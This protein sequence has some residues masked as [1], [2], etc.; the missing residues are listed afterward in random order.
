MKNAILTETGFVAWPARPWCQAP[1]SHREPG[2]LGL[3][4]CLVAGHTW[5]G[6]TCRSCGGVRDAHHESVLSGCYAK[7]RRCG[8]PLAARHE[9]AQVGC[10][11]QCRRCDHPGEE[12]HQMAG[13]V[14]TVCGV[15]IS[16]LP[17]R[18][19]ST[20]WTAH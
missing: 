6:C 1:A 5:K 16:R 17:T 7:C 9:W 20:S 2:W 19:L 11:L 18:D 14:C 10:Q 8:L 3:L 12:V 15:D 4:K 13:C